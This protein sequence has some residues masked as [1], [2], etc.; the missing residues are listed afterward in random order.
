MILTDVNVLIYAHRQDM[1]RHRDYAA[2]L[3]R[4]AASATAF[5]VSEI[6]P[7]RLREGRYQS[8]RLR[9][10]HSPA[11]RRWR[12]PARFGQFRTLCA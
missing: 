5:G 4:Q 7:Q 3:A 12:L 10:A 2:W 9:C 11:G 6:R 8:P 1:E